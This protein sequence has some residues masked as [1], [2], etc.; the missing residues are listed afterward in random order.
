ML[1]ISA[2]TEPFLTSSF[3]RRF[4][5]LPA[6]AWAAV[7]PEHHHTPVP[8]AVPLSAVITDRIGRGD[9]GATVLR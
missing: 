2:E 3:H 8:A 4:R 1:S 9:A 6:G 7:F 5:R